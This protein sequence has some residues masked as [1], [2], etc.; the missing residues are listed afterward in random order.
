MAVRKKR[1]NWLNWIL[2]LLVVGGAAGFWYWRQAKSKAAPITVKTD[3]IKIGDIVQSVA[4]NGALSPVKNVQVGSQVSG[5][6]REILV[7]FNSRVTNGQV[8]AK[9]DPSTY[10][11]AITRADAELANAKAALTYAEINFKRSKE[12][13]DARSEEH[14]SELQS[15]LHL[16]CRLLLEKKK[17]L[18]STKI[19][20][21]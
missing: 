10:D 16:V 15:R 21:A 12:L 20:S 13:H 3:I 18:I 19:T 14:T 7:D 6:I 4:A 11:Q 2:L 8:I 5:I 9:I 17:S 1:I